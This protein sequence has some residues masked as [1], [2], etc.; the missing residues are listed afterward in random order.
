MSAQE[1]RME[2]VLDYLYSREYRE[3][4][5]REE[6]RA[7]TLDPTPAHR[8]RLALGSPRAIPQGKPSKSWR[9]TRWTATA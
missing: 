4:G 2:A 6:T 5:V 7:G 9:S 3:R 8:S 1:Q